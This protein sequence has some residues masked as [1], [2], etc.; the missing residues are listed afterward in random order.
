MVS[1]SGDTS[2][3]LHL[4]EK[5]LF[6]VETALIGWHMVVPALVVLVIAPLFRA[7]FTAV[8]GGETEAP[9]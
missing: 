5:L 7:M 6:R 1:P 4:F 3:S 8:F 9:N 2:D